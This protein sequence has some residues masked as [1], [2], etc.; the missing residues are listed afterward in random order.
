MEALKAKF[1]KDFET[2]SKYFEDQLLQKDQEY[3]KKERDLQD[4][5]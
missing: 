3:E 5:L 2:K 1:H 4:K